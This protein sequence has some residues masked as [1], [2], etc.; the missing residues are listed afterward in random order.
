MSEYLIKTSQGTGAPGYLD[1]NAPNGGQWMLNG[2]HAKV[3]EGTLV[4]RL[5]AVNKNNF[6]WVEI[7]SPGPYQ[8]QRVWVKY[9]QLDLIEE[10]TP[11]PLPIPTGELV[12]FELYRVK[13]EF[14]PSFKISVVFK[15]I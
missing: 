5:T 6:C 3:P 11:V 2:K 15:K 13:V 10:P 1:D 12:E 9:S 14:V 8:G 7:L 4:K